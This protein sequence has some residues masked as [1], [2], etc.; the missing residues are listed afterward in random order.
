MTA[1]EEVTK[2]IR[3]NE[4]GYKLMYDNSETNL[5]YEEYITFV[6]SQEVAHALIAP[7]YLKYIGK[8]VGQ[9]RRVVELNIFCLVASLGL[10]VAF[11]LNA[12]KPTEL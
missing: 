11:L 2:F 1:V 3:D 10:N 4:P 12:L 9:I 5:T 7:G 6:T 8:M